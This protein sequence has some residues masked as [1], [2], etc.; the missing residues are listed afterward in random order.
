MEQSLFLQYIINHFPALVLR[1]VEKV[2][3]ENEAKLTYLF[4]K[5]LGK[6]FSVDGRWSS[7]IGKYKR[8]AADVVAMNSSLP[9]KSRGSLE[10]ATGKIPKMGM[11]LWLN[12]EQM[13]EIDTLI[14]LQT[15]ITEII[16]KILADVPAVINGIY[17]LLE[18]MF[19]EGFSTGVTS[20][21]DDENVGT[22]VRLNFGYIPENQFGVAVLWD[23]ANTSLVVDDINRVK[24]KATNDGNVLS[25]AYGDSNA[26]NN[27]IKS[28]QFKEQ[29][30]FN[31]GF[32]GSNIPT[33]TAEQANAVFKSLWGF[34]F[35]KVDRVIVTEKDGTSTSHKPWAAGR[36]V[37][38]ADE[39]V[40]E[41]VWANLA[42][43]NRMAQI[44][45]ATYQVA[46][47][48][49][50]VSKYHRIKP[51]FAEFT[52]S[53]ARVAPIISNVDRIYTLDT[54]TVQA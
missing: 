39:K 19:L 23:N 40:G 6:T 28:K 26:F 25:Y 30:A 20:I 43:K 14:A 46:D 16:A 3:G 12:E 24:A 35:T 51:T 10:R 36:I 22:A 21:E 9:L 54:T 2:N 37:F 41:V 15:P 44:K 38:T 17:E 47:D 27:L 49:I 50:L 34:V 11:E 32:V 29:F 45:T 48:Y 42:E 8:I 7:L 18:K 4:K 53:Q 13:T 1:H 31:Q 33:P 5:L 52:A